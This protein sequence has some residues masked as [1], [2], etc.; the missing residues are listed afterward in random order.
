MEFIALREGLPADFVRERG[1]ARPRHHPRQHQPPRA[2][3]DDHRPQLP[4][5]DQRQ[6]RQLR[7]LLVD[8][9]R[10]REAALGDA[11]GRRHGDGSLH[12]QADPRDARVDH[13]QLAGADRHR[14]DLSGAREGRRP[15]RGPHLGGLSR[16]DHRAVRAGRGLLHRP[17]RRAA[18]LH[19]AHRAARHRHRLARRVDH[20]QVVPGPSPGELPLHAL[21]RAVRDHAR[22]RRLVLAWRR[23]AARID[24]RRQRRGPV[25]R[26]ADAGRADEASPGSTTSR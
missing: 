26:A 7:G 19:P 24:C 13:P 5:E 20:R 21:P 17:C 8:R 3:A 11:V 9:R 1:G 14:A 15:A 10:G 22:L 25:R 4:G 23:P 2:R 16:H 18:A 6:H 12:R